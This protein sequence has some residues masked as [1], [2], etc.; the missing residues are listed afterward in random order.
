MESHAVISDVGNVI[1]NIIGDS[2]Q[3]QLL[4]GKKRKMQLRYCNNCNQ[5]TNHKLI[6][7]PL[8]EIWE[9][10]KCKAKQG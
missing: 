4:I 6:K 10:L 5:M 3:D 1:A 7:L 8:V 2:Y 9:C